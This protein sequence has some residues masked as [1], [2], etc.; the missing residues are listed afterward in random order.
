VQ[1]KLSASMTLAER[2]VVLAAKSR[3]LSRKSRQFARVL[4]SADRAAADMFHREGVPLYEDM[5]EA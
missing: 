3:F 2:E 4:A 5:G 1:D